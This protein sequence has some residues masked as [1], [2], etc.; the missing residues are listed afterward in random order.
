MNLL[1]SYQ[2]QP[3]RAYPTGADCVTKV[4]FLEAL[5]WV[6]AQASALEWGGAGLGL[7]YVLLAVRQN[8]ACWIFAL[9]STALYLAVFAQSHLYMQSALQAYFLAVAV[10]GW[11]AWKPAGTGRVV[12]TVGRRSQ[13]V[14]LIAL[15]FTSSVTAS[16]LSRETHSADPWLDALTTWASVYATWLQAQKVLENWLW[17]IAIDGVMVVLCVR[18]SLWLTAVL[19]LLFTVLAASGW[20]AWRAGAVKA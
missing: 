2:Y 16:V 18:Q 6:W 1:P 19:Y 5:Q 9:A 3:L 4:D 12:A 7:V 11:V 10:Y 14:A 13:A 17:W 20:R 8:R 15:L